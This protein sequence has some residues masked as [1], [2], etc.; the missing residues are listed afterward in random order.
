AH[1][2]V[3]RGSLDYA[4][5][6]GLRHLAAR[7][8]V[9]VADGQVSIS[10]GQGPAVAFYAASIAHLVDAVAAQDAEAKIESDIKL[11]KHPQY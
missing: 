9:T 6:A 1:V 11:Q 5:E 3:P 2:H 7:R 10:A 4:A 8:I